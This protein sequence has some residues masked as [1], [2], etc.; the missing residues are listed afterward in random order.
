MTL[1]LKDLPRVAVDARINT[2]NALSAYKT[3]EHLSSNLDMCALLSTARDVVG[4]NAHHILL[5]MRAQDLQISALL[6]ALKQAVAV[7]QKAWEAWDNGDGTKVGKL[8]ARMSSPGGRGYMAEI[9][10]IHDVIADVEAFLVEC[11]LSRRETKVTH[12][13][14]R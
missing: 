5:T 2:E 12:E 4:G 11:E 3:L 10:Q 1:N 13:D 7:A 8:L 6:A 9:D 14:N